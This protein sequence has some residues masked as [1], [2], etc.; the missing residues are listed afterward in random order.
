MQDFADDAAFIV[1]Q[2]A[3]VERDGFGMRVVGFSCLELNSR[4]GIGM[5]VYWVLGTEL[6]L[7][8]HNRDSYCFLYSGKLNPLTKTQLRASKVEFRS[9]LCCRPKP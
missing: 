7:S 4:M 9:S 5:R 8:Y 3:D 2:Q 1:L 6:T